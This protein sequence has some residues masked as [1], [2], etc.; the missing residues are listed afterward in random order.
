MDNK[1]LNQYYEKNVK[2]RRDETE[3]NTKVVLPLVEDILRYVNQ[4]DK[5]FM[6]QTVKV[7]SYHTHLK[8]KRAD[9]FDFSVVVDVGQLHWKSD[10]QPRYYGF[11]SNNNKV[12]SKGAALPS[13]PVGQYFTV[14]PSLRDQWDREG[15]N[16]GGASITFQNDIVPIKVKRRFKSL[17]AEAVNQPKIRSRVK[18][19]RLSES[20]AI[21]FSVELPNGKYPISIDL[22]PMIESKLEFKSEFNWPRVSS[23][24]PSN[25]KISCIKNIGIHEVAK[26]PFYW[27]LSFAACEKELLE[28]VDE[29]GTCRRK[30]LR[31]LKTLK[32]N[33]WCKPGVKKGLTSYHLKNVLFWECED[34]PSETEW[35]QELLAERVT[36]MTYRLLGYLQRGNLPLYFHT[37][38]NLLA[39]KDKD[40]LHQVATRISSFLHNPEQYLR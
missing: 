12:E 16:D 2:M 10:T 29:N 28:G 26:A 14:I 24:W 7:G 40:V 31:I 30:C 19:D 23:E 3:R 20:P 5:R 25:Q 15:L 35:Q 34:R 17:V 18:M 32:E 37:G 13:P 6:I 38:V 33:M 22:C 36:T 39:S 11:D 8:V 9:E 1:I 21:T 27:T 4:R